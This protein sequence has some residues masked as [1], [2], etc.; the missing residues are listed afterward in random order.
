MLH[1]KVPRSKFRG[2]HGETDGRAASCD[3]FHC[4]SKRLHFECDLPMH[5]CRE[6]PTTFVC[7]ATWAMGG[8]SRQMGLNEILDPSFER[9][10]AFP[11]QNKSP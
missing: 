5:R 1:D 6:P 4:A 11:H 7:F 8:K 2:F 9:E 10:N 3:E